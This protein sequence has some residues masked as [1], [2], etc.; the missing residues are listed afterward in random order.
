M[1]AA[2][3]AAILLAWARQGEMRKPVTENEINAR[4]FR[5]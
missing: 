2:N 5:C 1:K 3:G 4:I